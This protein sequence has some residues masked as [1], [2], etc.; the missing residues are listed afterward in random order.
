MLKNIYNIF[1]IR[2][3]LLLILT[4]RATKSIL[5]PKALIINDNKYDWKDKIILVVEDDDANYLYFKSL[6]KKT[7]A[8][9]VW[10]KNGHDALNFINDPDQQIDLIL[11][12]VLIPFVNG[13]EVT[14][15][16]RKKRKNLPVI[17][18]T[19]YTSKEIRQSCFLSGCNEF[20]VKPVLPEKLISTIA[21]YLHEDEDV[22][23][24]LAS[25]N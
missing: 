18:V 24:K 11:L 10:K 9:V 3:K 14:R 25:L 16:L 1:F 13:I 21:R 7:S 17:V 2:I 8:K 20:L 19:A 5:L 4:F 15:E 12:D 23:A 22:Y 6:L